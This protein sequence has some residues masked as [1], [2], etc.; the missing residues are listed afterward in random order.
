MR[1]VSGI[2]FVLRF[3]GG[4][5]LRKAREHVVASEVRCR[6]DPAEL[7]GGA[8]MAAQ[9]VVVH[10]GLARC[11]RHSLDLQGSFVTPC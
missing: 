1:A 8:S 3:G 2:G 4:V 9:A 10:L 5:G 11:S 6:F 7:A